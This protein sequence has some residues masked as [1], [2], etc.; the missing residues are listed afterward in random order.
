M[1]FWQ[2]LNSGLKAIQEE[3]ARK[4]E[5]QQEIELRK[6]ERDEARAYEYDLWKE[7]VLQDQ[8]AA[9]LPLLVEKKR[10]MAAL[11]AE[12]AQLGKYFETRLTD[13][14]EETRQA[15]T[16]LAVQDPTYSEALI[17]SVQ[18]AESEL[19]RR[20][21]GAEILKM[22]SLI[23]QTKPENMSLEDWT[24]Q[25]AGMTVTSGSS[26]DF[27]ATM[28]K[29]LSGDVTYEDVQK[30]QMELLM[31]TGT[32]LNLIPDVD[33]SVIMGPDPQT[34]IQLRN[35]AMTTMQ[36][37][38]QAD[39]AATEQQYQAETAQGGMPSEELAAKNME[40]GLIAAL[41]GSEKEAAL[42]NYYA[43]TLLPRLAEREPR[44]KTVFPE[45]FQPAGQ[46]DVQP[47]VTYE[48]VN[49]KLVAVTQ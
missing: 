12:R 30:T 10:E 23:E 45:Y 47:T 21:T 48:Y 3:K 36:D 33:T 31:P 13:L 25:A 49:G 40:L 5:R 6:A 8:V 16:N 46:V 2:G 29:L 18:K 42:F 43:P 7:K 24:K 17:G 11:A 4:E 32:S 35:L 34:S 41:E 27:D 26:I 20:V 15:F 14:P 22:T 37:Q 39:R 28:E 44:F 1:G 19:N 38:F 9:T